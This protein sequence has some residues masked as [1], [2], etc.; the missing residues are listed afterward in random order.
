MIQSRCRLPNLIALCLALC[1]RSAAGL[2]LSLE[3]QAVAI[4]GVS[5]GGKVILLGVARET[6]EYYSVIVRRDLVVT[7]SDGDGTVRA[8]LETAMASRSIWIAVDLA[9]GSFVT[10]KP[11]DSPFT[12]AALDLGIPGNLIPG[13][14]ALREERG[15]VE[16]LLARPGST[17]GAWALTAGEGGR[18]DADL[19]V[20]GGITMRLAAMTRV[21]GALPAPAA[22][23]TGDIVVVVDPQRMEYFAGKVRP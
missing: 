14:A 12:E 10:A 4:S 1:A 5:P 2:D 23:L 15:R 22:L 7:D 17:P 19:T 18:N 16:V 21:E 13:Q 9:A 6:A 8:S 20:D 11:A 3:L